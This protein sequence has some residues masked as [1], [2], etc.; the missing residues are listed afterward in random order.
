MTKPLIPEDAFDDILNIRVLR[1]AS[2][3]SLIF[4]RETL[5]PAGL[6]VQEWRILV[7]LA[8]M[9]DSHLRALA[10]KASLDSAHASRV[11]SHMVSRGLIAR[12][13]DTRDQRRIVFSITKAGAE[14]F[15]RIWPR[16]KDL[17]GEFRQIYSAEE[18]TVLL[19]L[20]DRAVEH[21]DTLLERPR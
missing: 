3:L 16:A 1:L 17:A 7:S 11:A 8:Q 9:G 15:F 13:P 10:R 20:I 19:T 21:A 4:V 6:S 14:V 2:K 18:F 5:R 12:H